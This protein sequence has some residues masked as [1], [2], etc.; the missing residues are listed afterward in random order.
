M[1]SYNLTEQ[2]TLFECIDPLNE[3][4]CG[5]PLHH[6]TLAEMVVIANDWHDVRLCSAKIVTAGDVE[7][8]ARD[9][10]RIHWDALSE[11]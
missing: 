3:E 10:E 9:I 11:V 6:G 5:Q 2:A 4:L 8:R 1:P 7:Y